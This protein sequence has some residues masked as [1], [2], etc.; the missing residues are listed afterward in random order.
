MVH[1]GAKSL[2]LW[3]LTVEAC[4]AE[5]NRID[6]QTEGFEDLFKK[7]SGKIKKKVIEDEH[8]QGLVSE[9]R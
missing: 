3:G 9:G 1:F 6:Y 4:F 5:E 7:R 2:F 8:F